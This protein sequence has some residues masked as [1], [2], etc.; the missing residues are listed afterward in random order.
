MRLEQVVLTVVDLGAAE[1]FYREVLQ[2]PVSARPGQVTVTVGTGSVV[3]ERGAPFEGAHHLA[4]GIAPA[5]HELARAWLRERVDPIVVDGSDVVVGGP[6][7]HSRSVYFL[8]PEGIV[9][10]LIARDADAAAP[11]GDGPAPRILC[12]SEVGIGVPDVP[13]AVGALGDGLGLPPFPTQ[14]PRFAPV[15]GHDG[16]LIVVEQ[17]RVWFPTPCQQA[18]RGP[19]S[20]RMVGPR[21][22][23]LELRPSA[24]VDASASR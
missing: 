6:G 16:L 8:G 7:W 24:T 3:L 23:H 20:V 13:A 15:G 17:D 10:E 12:L 5:D 1:S 2:L 14:G 19:V 18:A 4:F 21:A 9:L 22:G 11:A